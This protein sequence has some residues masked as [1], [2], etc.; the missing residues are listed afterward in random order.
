MRLRK[1][2]DVRT[3]KTTGTVG[4]KDDGK[5]FF[6]GMASGADGTFAGM[7]RRKGEAATIKDLL[8]NGWSNGYLYLA[9]EE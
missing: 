5:P 3:K 4:I 2:Q 7:I 6:T 8:A 9:E 1:L